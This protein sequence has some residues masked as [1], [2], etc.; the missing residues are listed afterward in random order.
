MLRPQLL[1]LLV[2]L[3]ASTLTGQLLAQD[4]RV[5]TTVTDEGRP[6]ETPT[7]MSHSLTIFHAGKV[8]D[9][10][11]KVG[12]VVILDPQQSRFVLLGA[13]QKATIVSF[14]ELNQ[15]LK[16]ATIA[17]EKYVDELETKGDRLAAEH[18]AAI[19]FQLM[20]TFKE[21]FDPASRKLSL[22]GEFLS[23]EVQAIVP[24]SESC[25]ETYLAY[26]TW[27]AKLNSILH[28]HSTMPEPRVHLNTVLLKR[29]L[30]PSQVTLR[31]KVDSELHLR[32]DHKFAWELEAVDK[33][34]IT[35]W[36][37]SIAAAQTKWVSFQQYQQDLY[38]RKTA[39][40]D[41]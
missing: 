39:L 38:S 29:K 37:R 14:E 12:E 6:G 13:S 2:I 19:R 40:R 9:F 30:L 16:S 20:P 21:S 18:G 32:A 10:M 15:F 36:E 41:R 5:Y 22:G 25:A 27:A 26:A 11:E 34:L 23:Y 4:M 33:R 17:A 7:L 1:A 3:I 8:Y 24:P 31:V 35:Q 28:P